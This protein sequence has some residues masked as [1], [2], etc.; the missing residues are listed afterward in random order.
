[1]VAGTKTS[2]AIMTRSSRDSLIPANIPM[3]VINV[4][5]SAVV[6]LVGP[7]GAGKSTFA[8]RH[9]PG[10][11]VI[12]PDD[13]R[14][15]LGGEAS[16]QHHNTEVFERVHRVLEARAEAGLLTVVDATNTRGPERTEL[17]WHA[18]RH[19]RPLLAVVLDLPPDTCLARNASRPHPVPTRV[20]RKQVADLR[21]VETDL[22]TEGYRAFHIF[23]SVAQ[24]DS[25]TVVI[26]DRMAS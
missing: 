13:Y 11:S 23:R 24:V 8:A 16:T 17:A 2:K 9:F 18:H 1:M 7:A 12:S 5:A 15:E 6:I 26:E 20:I 19:R 14:K 25:A 10:E 3:S 21:H 22:E 4:P